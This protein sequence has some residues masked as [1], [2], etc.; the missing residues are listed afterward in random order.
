MDTKSSK[1]RENTIVSFLE[2]WAF[3]K[4]I[5]VVLMIMMGIVVIF[6]AV[7]LGVSIVEEIM[8][9]SPIGLI[10]VDHLPTLLGLFLW[11]LIGVELLDSV[12]M[13]LREHAVHVETVLSVGMIAIS[14]KVIVT[15]I[16]EI[17]ALTLIGLAT[18]LTALS[19]GY[20]LVRKSHGKPDIYEIRN[21]A[22]DKEEH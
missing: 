22:A 6:S 9:V 14:N 7:D 20:F 21:A 10:S 19:I 4:V 1:N 8:V 15:D 12:R 11:V 17:S 18:I 13:Y 16:H 3:R 5:A 2:K